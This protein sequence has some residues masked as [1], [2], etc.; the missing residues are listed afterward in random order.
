MIEQFAENSAFARLSA[1][2]FWF[3]IPVTAVQK[4]NFTSWSVNVQIVP[5]KALTAFMNPSFE[6]FLAASSRL[7]LTAFTYNP[8]SILP[9]LDCC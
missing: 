9:P 2:Q 6:R 1:G 3:K 7:F 4:L 5:Q 8:G